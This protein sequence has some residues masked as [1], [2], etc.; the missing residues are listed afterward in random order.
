MDAAAPNN[1]TIAHTSSS[2]LDGSGVL[3]GAVGVPIVGALKE[4]RTPPAA[5]PVVGSEA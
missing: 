1:A 4:M 3:T 5:V 2:R